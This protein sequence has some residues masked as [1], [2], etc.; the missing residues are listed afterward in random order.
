MVQH[1]L[2]DWVWEL[3]GHGQQVRFRLVAVLVGDELDI[4]GSAV[5][6]SVAVGTESASDEINNTPFTK[7]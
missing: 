5:R 3:G 2:R 4:D 6:G 7:L 1:E